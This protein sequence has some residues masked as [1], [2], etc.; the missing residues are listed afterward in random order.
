M[1]SA[2]IVTAAEP[3]I[4][5]APAIQAAAF[6]IPT[7]DVKVFDQTVAD[8]K[9][10][11]ETAT[12]A[13]SVVSGKALKSAKDLVAF[14]QG[15][16]EAFTQAS[17]ILVAGSQDLMRQMAESS[18][19]AFAETVSAYRALVAAKTPTERLSLQANFVR[20]STLKAVSETGRFTHAGLELVQSAAAPVTARAVVAATTIAAAKL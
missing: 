7:Y 19:A 12:A 10:G 17:K 9:Q 20:S 11:V 14:N 5:A 13:A 8:L 2:K 15:T 1:P 4:G 18:Q 3:S 16:V 6:E